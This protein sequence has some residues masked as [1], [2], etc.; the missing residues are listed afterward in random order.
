M[1][2]TYLPLVSCI[3]IIHHSA[4]SFRKS[5]RDRH[6]TYQTQWGPPTHLT[7]NTGARI[8]AVGLGTWQSKPGEVRKAVAFALKDG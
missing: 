5:K 4:S 3:F 1:V 6:G 8:P 2:E 7:L